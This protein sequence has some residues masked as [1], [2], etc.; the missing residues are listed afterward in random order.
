MICYFSMMQKRS[1][2]HFLH[3]TRKE[4][5]GTLLLTCL[6]LL[7]IATPFI[8]ALVFKEKMTDA[9]ELKSKMALLKIKTADS[10]EKKY[11]RN[12]AEGQEREPYNSYQSKEHKPAP[13]LFYFDPNTLSAPGWKKLGVADKAI[14]T[15][16][17]YLSKGGKFRDP[18]DIKKI[19]GLHKDQVEEL[20]PYVKITQSANSTSLNYPVYEKKEFTKKATSIVDINNAD[21]SAYISLP[22]IGPGYAR[23]IV[24]FRDKLGGFYKTEQVAETFG[25]PDSVFQK[26]NSYLQVSGENLRK[27][28][29]NTVTFDE[30]KEHPYFRYQLANAIIQYRTQHGNFSS[31]GE[32]KKIMLITEEVFEKVSPYLTVQ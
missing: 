19:W 25:L 8:Y 20:L 22:G 1:S 5:N 7:L 28:N 26:I 21:S 9:A 2:H 27:I 3:F 6:I 15:I 11:H 12:Y 32:I 18:E 13:D 29:I 17:N 16:Q 14:A 30:L 31:V 10:T 4:K 23:R 24:K